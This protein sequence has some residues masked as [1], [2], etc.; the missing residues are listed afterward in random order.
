MIVDKD[1]KFFSLI[2]C[3]YLVEMMLIADSN[4]FTDEIVRAKINPRPLFIILQN[5]NWAIFPLIADKV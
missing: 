3:S 4:I 1:E 2:I 5:N